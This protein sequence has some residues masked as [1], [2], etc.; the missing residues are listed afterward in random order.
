MLQIG[1]VYN[2]SHP[3]SVGSYYRGPL[4]F[5]DRITPGQLIALNTEG[6]RTLTVSNGN[7]LLIG[8]HQEAID[9]YGL[10]INSMVAQRPT[11][12]AFGFYREGH[13]VVQIL[14]VNLWYHSSGDRIDTVHPSGL[15]RATR[16][17][18][19]VLD[20]IDGASSAELERSA[21]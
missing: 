20:K 13:T 18:A 10:V 12:D 19:Y 14:D 11:G 4:K 3:S 9:R 21:P 6:G 2:V 17:Y 8:F 7:P 15:Q 5:Y 16:L 1:L